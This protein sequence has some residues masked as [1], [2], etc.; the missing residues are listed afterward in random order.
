MCFLDGWDD[1]GRNHSSKNFLKYHYITLF[2]Q[3]CPESLPGGS[4]LQ[5]NPSSF[6][7]PRRCHSYGVAPIVKFIETPQVENRNES[8]RAYKV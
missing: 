8:N 1:D 5:K 2:S 7:L 3:F 4:A 6:K